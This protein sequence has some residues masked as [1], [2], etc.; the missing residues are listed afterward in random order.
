MKPNVFLGLGCDGV[1][2]KI[3]YIPI[4]K[5]TELDLVQDFRI[6]ESATAAIDK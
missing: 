6:L 4:N 1:R 2:K 3:N 5:F